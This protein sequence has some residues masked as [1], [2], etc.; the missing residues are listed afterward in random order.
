MTVLRF[1][2]GALGHWMVASAGHGEGFGAVRVYGSHGVADMSGGK[3]KL[4]GRDAVPWSEVSAPYL[5][6]TIPGDSF[7]H[8]FAELH[9][10]ITEGKP[11]ISSGERAL[12]VLA[13]VYACLEASQTRR[14]VRVSDILSG[15][16]R[17]YEETIEAARAD[18]PTT[19]EV[20][21]RTS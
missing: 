2:S 1:E 7:A 15:S 5:D 14:P 20:A 18:W 19:P 11:P 10:L 13:V 17:A 12:E 4:D 16:S 9:A 3:V 8:S 6:E 21:A